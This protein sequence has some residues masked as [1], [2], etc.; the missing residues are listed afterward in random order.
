MNDAPQESDL[1][2]CPRSPRRS[3]VDQAVN[4]ADRSQEKS[5]GRATAKKRLLSL[6]TGTPTTIETPDSV[7]KSVKKSKR[8]LRVLHELFQLPEVEVLPKAHLL[9]ALRLFPFT[10]TPLGY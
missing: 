3:F 8:Q 7:P 5:N 4:D 10:M 9:R 6:V 2:F 1:G